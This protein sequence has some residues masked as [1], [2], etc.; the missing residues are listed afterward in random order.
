MGSTPTNTQERGIFTR[1]SIGYDI[2]VTVERYAS[3]LHK[4]NAAV[5]Q[6]SDSFLLI[7]INDL[8][9]AQKITP[10]V[11]QRK[12]AHS[13]TLFQLTNRYY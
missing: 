2:Q 8:L 4:I 7:L 6:G 3:S 12:T 1:L 9:L 13:I 11:V 10:L 5:P